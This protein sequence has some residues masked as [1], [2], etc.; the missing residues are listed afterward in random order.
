LGKEGKGMARE[1]EGEERGKGR[2]GEE[3]R[4]RGEMKGRDPTKFPEKLMPLLPRQ[5]RDTVTVLWA[6]F[7]SDFKEATLL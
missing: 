5:V 7:P 1:A 4:G 6:A 2:R 3:G